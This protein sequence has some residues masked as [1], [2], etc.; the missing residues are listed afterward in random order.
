MRGFWDIPAADCSKTAEIIAFPV[1]RESM[2]Y[3]T[4]IRRILRG[5]VLRFRQRMK[6]LAAFE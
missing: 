6:R 1:M 3:R 4:H 2:G 5:F